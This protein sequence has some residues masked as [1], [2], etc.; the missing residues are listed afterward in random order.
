M[1]YQV[2]DVLYY[3]PNES[4]NHRLV[5]ITK[6]GR[7]WLTINSSM[8]INKDT[9]SVDGYGYS[10]PG[11]CYRT[12][13]DYLE[14]SKRQELWR[15]IRGEVYAYRIPAHLSTSDLQ[16]IYDKLMAACAEFTKP[17]II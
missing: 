11:R 16:L 7:K 14:V 6:V 15:K 4:K 10:S 8:R 5:T 2:G 12:E 9:L 17:E 1:N 3:V 13:A